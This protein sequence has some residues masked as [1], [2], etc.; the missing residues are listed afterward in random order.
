MWSLGC[1]LVEMVTKQPIF[2]GEDTLGQIIEI[3]K[4]LGTPDETFLIHS[5]GFKD[6]KLP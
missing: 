5:S 6:I 2:T 1:I 4:I 3:I